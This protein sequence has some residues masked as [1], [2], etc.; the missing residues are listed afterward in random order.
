MASDTTT[1]APTQPEQAATTT[2]T[3][4]ERRQFVTVLFS[5]IMGAPFG[6]LAGAATVGVI[7]LPSIYRTGFIALCGSVIV[8]GAWFEF[9]S[10]PEPH[11]LDGETV[12]HREQASRVPGLFL[13]GIGL[14]FLSIGIVMLF[15]LTIPLLY[16]AL[17]LVAGV[18]CYASG[19]VTVWLHS[20]TVYIGTNKRIIRAHWFIRPRTKTVEMDDLFRI[21][22]GVGLFSWTDGVHH[23]RIETPPQKDIPDMTFRHIP[24]Q[25]SLVQWLSENTTTIT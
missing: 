6:A 20:R 13:G 12:L 16:P 5:F 3:E 24:K 15:A 23:V 25:S 18:Y 14:V 4:T 17:V 22:K 19:L 9:A 8:I 2:R 11:L 1:E 10:A 7:T 21:V